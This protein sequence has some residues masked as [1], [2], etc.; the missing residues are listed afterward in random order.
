MIRFDQS[1]LHLRRYALRQA[2]R[3]APLISP[4]ILPRPRNRPE[5]AGKRT[6]GHRGRGSSSPSV[7]ITPR[8]PPTLPPRPDH[9][10]ASGDLPSMHRSCARPITPSI[11][12]HAT[13]VESRL[14]VATSVR[15]APD[16][17]FRTKG[18]H[19]IAPGGSGKRR[20]SRFGTHALTHSRTSAPPPHL[21]R[22]KGGGARRRPRPRPL[23][24]P[25][26]G[27]PAGPP[28]RADHGV[29]GLRVPCG[30]TRKIPQIPPSRWNDVWSRHR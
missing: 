16:E 3:F 4:S 6:D 5:P 29:G 2:S 26:R 22:K 24:P 23:I 13:E 7:F 12:L 10:R 27:A 19:G 18:V 20:I 25:A 17:Q 15:I 21:G 8:P 1:R 14:R 30:T 9:V 11:G 28:S